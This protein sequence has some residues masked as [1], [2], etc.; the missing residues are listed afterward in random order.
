MPCADYTDL[1]LH[2]AYFE[3]LTQAVKEKNLIVLNFFDAL[4][5]A[6]VNYQGRWH[7]NKLAA[8]SD[9]YFHKLF[10]S[11]TPSRMAILGDSVFLNNVR[12]TYGKIIRDSMPNERK[13]I[14]DSAEF[15]AVDLILQIVT[16]SE[17]KS[18]MW[19]CE[20]DQG[21]FRPSKDAATCRRTECDYV[22]FLVA[23]IC[24]TYERVT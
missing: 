14:T 21:A 7:D 15:T 3:G 19:G 10:D 9:L 22:Y 13:D 11:L 18:T 20:S 6:T 12:M 16:T 24:S 23:V 8:V 5:N 17:R 4:I 1:D 2:K